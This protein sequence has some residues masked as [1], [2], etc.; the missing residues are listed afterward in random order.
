MSDT[1]GKMFE[2][3]HSQIAFLLKERQELLRDKARRDLDSAI[4]DWWDF[5][6]GWKGVITNFYKDRPFPKTARE[7][8]MLRIEEWLAEGR[9]HGSNQQN[10]DGCECEK[11]ELWDKL[12]KRIKALDTAQSAFE[13]QRVMEEGTR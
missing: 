8:F 9:P 3:L 4:L 1:A 13:A 5:D 11:C 10:P 2:E 7:A 6:Q 12:N